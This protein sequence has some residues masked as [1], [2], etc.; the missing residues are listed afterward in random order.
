MAKTRKLWLRRFLTM[1]DILARVEE[2]VNCLIRKG[3]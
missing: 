2:N 1:T 3:L